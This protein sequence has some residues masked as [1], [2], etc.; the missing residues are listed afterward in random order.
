M[1]NH[2][3]REHHAACMSTSIRSPMR[4]VPSYSISLLLCGLCHHC[5]KYARSIT[6]IE[7]LIIAALVLSIEQP[8]P[9]STSKIG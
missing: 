8:P 1:D 4:G 9:Q 7:S 3:Q 6:I 2:T 5:P